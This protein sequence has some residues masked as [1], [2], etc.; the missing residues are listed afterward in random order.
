MKPTTYLFYTKYLN[1]SPHSTDVHAH[2]QS[3]RPIHA[4]HA[5]HRGVAP[6]H[7][8]GDQC[9]YLKTSLCVRRQG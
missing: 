6:A 2:A 8:A 9:L 3:P 1:P 4:L 5:A 7:G